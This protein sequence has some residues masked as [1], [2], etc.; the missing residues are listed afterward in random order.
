MVF[1]LSLFLVNLGDNVFTPAAQAYLGDRIP[2]D[3][4]GRALAVLEMG[5]SLSFI[6]CVPLAGLLI[7]RYG[8]QSP[9]VVLTAAGV[10]VTLLF[11]GWVP[12][13]IRPPV[14]QSYLFSDFKKVMS[15]PPALAGLLMGWVS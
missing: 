9:F 12:R 2:Y 10:L 4:R 11:I 1:F 5:W 13:D 8:W 14:E 7:D 6:L 15:Y 3:Q